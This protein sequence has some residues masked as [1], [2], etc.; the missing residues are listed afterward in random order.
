MARSP[1][2]SI[3]DHVLERASHNRS[4]T[5]LVGPDDE[6]RYRETMADRAVTRLQRRGRDIHE[7]FVPHVDHSVLSRTARN[8]IARQLDEVF[9]QWK[10]Q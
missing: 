6:P 3:P 4:V 10:V 1:A 7:H 8:L 9:A 5:L 2:A